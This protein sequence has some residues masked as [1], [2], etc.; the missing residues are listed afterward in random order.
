MDKAINQLIGTIYQIAEQKD[1]KEH[2][3]LMLQQNRAIKLF[4]KRIE[5]LLIPG[6]VLPKGTCCEPVRE[7]FYLGTSCPKCKRP[8]RQNL[9]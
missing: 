2:G 8:F 6:V 9:K 5:N 3:E 4:K 7:G 1:K